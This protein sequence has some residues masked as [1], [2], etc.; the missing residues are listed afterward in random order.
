M[1]RTLLCSWHICCRRCLAIKYNGRLSCEHRWPVASLPAVKFLFLKLVWVNTKSLNSNMR[2]PTSLFYPRIHVCLVFYFPL[3]LFHPF[4]FHDTNL[5]FS[6]IPLKYYVTALWKWIVQ[7]CSSN[8]SPACRLWLCPVSDPR[9]LALCA[10][11]N[12]ILQLSANAPWGC[13]LHA[14]WHFDLRGNN[15]SNQRLS[16]WAHNPFVTCLPSALKTSVFLFG[17]PSALGLRHHH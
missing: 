14:G 2:P 4:F 15:E 13:F 10:T 17:F 8:Q 9:D 6:S 3:N 11:G 7:I 5:S 12:W 16:H 1:W